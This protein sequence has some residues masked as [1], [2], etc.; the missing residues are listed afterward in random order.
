MRTRKLRSWSRLVALDPD[1]L[2]SAACAHEPCRQSSGFEEGQRRH[3]RITHYQRTAHFLDALLG[4]DEHG[5]AGRIE[6][7]E[8]SDVEG[9]VDSTLGDDQLR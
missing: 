3:G 5:E 2:V 8:L 6:I 4:H 1:E 9:N 7:S